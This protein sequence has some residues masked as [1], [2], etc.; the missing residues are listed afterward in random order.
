MATAV[1]SASCRNAALVAVALLAAGCASAPPPLPPSRGEQASAPVDATLCAAVVTDLAQLDARMRAVETRIAADR[2]R[3][4]T[5]GYAAA[6][7][8]PPALLMLAA[9]SNA[10]TR[11]SVDRLYQERDAILA[12]AAAGGCTLP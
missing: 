11:Q 5:A 7:L 6:V 9:D 12:R 3:D 2:S 8:F 4:Q 10:E 1:L